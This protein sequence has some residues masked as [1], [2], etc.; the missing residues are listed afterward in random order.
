MQ[1]S[2]MS[3]GSIAAAIYCGELMPEAILNESHGISNPG[4]K[5]MKYFH[6][7]LDYHRYVGV[8]Y[9]RATCSLTRI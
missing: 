4:K 6:K 3:F 8:L 7:R 9:L 2:L 5:N 1:R